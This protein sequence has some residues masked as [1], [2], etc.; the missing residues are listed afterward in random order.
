[1]FEKILVPLDGSQIA[2]CVLPHVAAIAK[3]GIRSMTL[4]RVMESARTKGTAVNPVD[5]QLQKSEAQ[6]YLEETGSV[7]TNLLEDEPHITLLEGRA[8]ERIV[9]YADQEEVDLVVLSS[10]G[11][12]GL[13]RWNISSTTQ[14]IIY[15]VGRSVLLIRAYQADRT[16]NHNQAMEAVRYR[17]ILVPLD[18]SQRAEHVLTA[19]VAFAEQHDAE[20]WLVHV[21]TKPA[22]M[23]RMPLTNEDATLVEKIF[24]RNQ[25][26]AERYL[27]QLRTRLPERTQSYV[28]TNANVPAVLHDFVN[29]HEIDLVLLSAHGASGEGQWPFGSI[30]AS[31]VNFGM[32]PLL[33]MQ[34]MPGRLA[35]PTYV[36]RIARSTQTSGPR[37]AGG[38]NIPDETVLKQAEP[39]G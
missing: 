16:D 27:E 38:E 10:H 1:M 26:Y 32:T 13:H 2:D 18:G 31:F 4:L 22:M 25:S 15:R 28:L 14:K 11:E 9:E 36:D 7:L 5:W 39:Q 20:I 33:I 12:S 17:R 30:V 6:S 29:Q 8:A 35:E 34:D 19:A 3:M 23:Q 24:E 37:T 21:V